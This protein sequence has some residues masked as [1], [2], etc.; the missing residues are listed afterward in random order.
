MFG[1]GVSIVD[2]TLL[3]KAVRDKGL[4]VQVKILEGPWEDVSGETI[5]RVIVAV[6]SGTISS[7]SDVRMRLFVK[8]AT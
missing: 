5:K 4:A 7:A 1:D 8:P 6:N 3:V 2:V